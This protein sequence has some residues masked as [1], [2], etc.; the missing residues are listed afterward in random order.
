MTFIQTQLEMISGIGNPSMV[1]F[2][3]LDDVN[4]SKPTALDTAGD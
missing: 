3:N 1:M 4:A 2:S